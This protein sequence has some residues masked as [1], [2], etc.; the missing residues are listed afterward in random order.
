MRSNMNQDHLFKLEPPVERRVEERSRGA[1][2]WYT[3]YE[4]R[5]RPH[6][7][8]TNIAKQPDRSCPDP[9]QRE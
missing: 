2:P 8:S 1:V 4:R 7:Y 5:N 3:Q 6:D 9:H